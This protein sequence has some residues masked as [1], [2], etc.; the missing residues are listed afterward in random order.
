MCRGD[1]VHTQFSHAGPHLHGSGESPFQ[2][3]LINTSRTAT[4][5]P[6][7]LGHSQQSTSV[8]QRRPGAGAPERASLTNY[9]VVAAGAG[10]AADAVSVAGLASEFQVSRMINHFPSFR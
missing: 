4:D 8:E 7:D 3:V 1:P 6:A 10:T 5:E 9:L 2:P